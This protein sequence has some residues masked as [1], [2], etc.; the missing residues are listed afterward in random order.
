MKRILTVSILF[1]LVIFANG[2]IDMKIYYSADSLVKYLVSDNWKI[3]FSPFER[4]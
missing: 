4:A 3:Y 1:M 2:Q